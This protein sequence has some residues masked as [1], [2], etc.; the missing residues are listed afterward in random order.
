M[1]IGRRRKNL[2]NFQ[3]RQSPS[4][5]ERFH[6]HEKKEDSL[7]L[8]TN[9]TQSWE[10]MRHSA[11]GWPTHEMDSPLNY[12]IFSSTPPASNSL[13]RQKDLFASF[14][15][16]FHHHFREL[17]RVK[18]CEIFVSFKNSSFKG[19]RGTCLMRA[20]KEVAGANAKI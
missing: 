19:V 7:F 5:A 17:L 12:S 10:L 1:L 8:R 9:N 6:G 14:A 15:I 4:R 16:G 13:S 11:L 3:P 20:G 2:R 18:Y